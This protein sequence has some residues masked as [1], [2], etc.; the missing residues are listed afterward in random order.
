MDITSDEK[1][2]HKLGQKMQCRF[3]FDNGITVDI[4][5][6]KTMYFL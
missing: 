2:T 3:I 1:C 4:I 5:L 6:H